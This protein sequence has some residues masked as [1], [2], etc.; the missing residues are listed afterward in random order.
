MT[1]HRGKHLAWLAL[2]GALVCSTGARADDQVSLR[3]D[4]VPVGF[5]A[6]FFLALDR[7]YYKAEKLDVT[8]GDGKGSANTVQLIGSGAD[9]FGWADSAV[10]AM[11][12]PGSG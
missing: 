9:T 4:W 6:P 12:A 1:R 2:L 10:A 8:I 11:A 3:L 7:G 5:H